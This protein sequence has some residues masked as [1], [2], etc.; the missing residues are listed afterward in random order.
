MVNSMERAKG[1]VVPEG[2]KLSGLPMT[3][4]TSG[5]LGALQKLHTIVR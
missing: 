3:A 5:S 1:F 4:S 2:E